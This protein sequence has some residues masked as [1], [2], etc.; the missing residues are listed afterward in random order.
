MIPVLQLDAVTCRFADGRRVVSALDDVCL[1]VA[2][3]ELVA[4]MGPSGSGKSTLVH[5]SCGLVRP[6]SGSVRIGGH[7]PPLGA[8]RWWAERRRRDVGVVHSW[9]NAWLGR[10]RFVVRLEASAKTARIA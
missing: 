7:S 2:P 10:P 8:R 9:P 4:V 5:M 6:S 3:S 1:M